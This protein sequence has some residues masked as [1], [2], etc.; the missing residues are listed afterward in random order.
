MALPSR[1]IVVSAITPAVPAFLVVAARIGAEQHPARLQRGMQFSQHARQFLAGHM[2]Q[3]RVG[4]RAVEVHFRQIEPA[5]ILPPDFA[6]AVG[7]GHLDESRRAIDRIIASY[8]AGDEAGAHP[9]RT[10]GAA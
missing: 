4:E 7:P 9:I 1:Q 3:G 8:A 2:K 6:T 10:W 5:K